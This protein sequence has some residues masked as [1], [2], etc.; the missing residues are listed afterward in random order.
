MPT[1]SASQALSILRDG[2]SGF[3][4]ERGLVFD[5]AL[6][7][8]GQNS[9]KLTIP[10]GPLTSGV[11]YDYLRLELDD[12]SSA[13]NPVRSYRN[14]LPARVVHDRGRKVQE[15]GNCAQVREP[16]PDL[17]TVQQRMLK[18]DVHSAFA[19]GLVDGV[20]KSESLFSAKIP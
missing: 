17:L 12:S 18:L 2:I 20:N 15:C 1:E 5:A 6:M 7:R 8:S 10:A 16:G 9:L 14:R 13:P 19:E 11:I 3:W 4:A